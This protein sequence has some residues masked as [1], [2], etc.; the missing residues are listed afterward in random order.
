MNHQFR[1]LLEDFENN[2]G[3]IPYHCEVRW[4]SRGKVLD[5]FF[6]LREEIAMF[7]EMKEKA[8]AELQ[9]AKW[10]SDLAF[11]TDLT[12]HLNELN[13]SLQGK[14]QIITQMYDEILAFK[15]KLRLWER[16]LQNNNSDHFPK[17]ASIKHS[18]SQRDLKEYSE[19]LLELHE[20][21]ESRFKDLEVLASQFDIFVRPFSI[22][23]DSV[24]STLQLELI[25]LQCDREQKDKF[26]NK[27]NLRDF[28][29]KFPH[30]RFLR[31]N[32]QAANILSM[33]GTTYLCEQI[34]SVMKLRKHG[35]TSNLSQENLKAVLR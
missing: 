32:Q 15:M 16:Q 23:I 33:F 24:P 2:Y 20:Q 7:M 28:Y 35:Q 10:I 5:R 8:V 27:E 4:L 26:L 9:D 21:F 25:D 29:Q 6:D 13:V 14:R 31:L 22:N 30:L 34:F 11:L 1:T 12:N 19:I 17:L 18:P 3:D